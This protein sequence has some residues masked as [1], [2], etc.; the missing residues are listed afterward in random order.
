MKIFLLTIMLSGCVN[1]DEYTY[2]RN[3]YLHNNLQFTHYSELKPKP[4]REHLDI[5]V[6]MNF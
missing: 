2:Q 5:E 1:I 3:L 4:E 6:E